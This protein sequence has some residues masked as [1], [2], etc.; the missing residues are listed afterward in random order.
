MTILVVVLVFP[1]GLSVHDLMVDVLAIYDQVVLDV[2]D[3]VPGIRECLGHLA[4][5]VKVRADGGLALLKLIGD[6][7]DN[8]T[9]VL[10]SMEHHIECANL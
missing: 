2:E 5:L 7:V 9:E 6:I 10:E 1:L 4:E 3:E 8:V